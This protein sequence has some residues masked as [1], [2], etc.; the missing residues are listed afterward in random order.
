V[1]FLFPSISIPISIPMKLAVRFPFP[2]ESHG[3]HGT[4]GNS[5]YILISSR[6]VDGHQMYFGRSVIGK[7]STIGTEISSI[8][9]LIFT[10]SQKMRNL[11]SFSTSLNSEIAITPRI[12]RLRPNLIQSFITSQGTRC[13]CSRSNVKGQGYRVIGKCHRVK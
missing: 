11:A 13:K 4:H 1:E 8:P 2:W 3:T 7:A 5:Q 6:A 12:A 10:G 9:L